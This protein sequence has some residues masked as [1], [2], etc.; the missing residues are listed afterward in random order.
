MPHANANFDPAQR[1]TKNPFRAMAAGEIPPAP[2]SELLGLKI[3]ELNEAAGTCTIEFQ[4]KP[5]FV[6][7]IG[8]IQGGFL[9]A[10]LDDTFSIALLA[11]LGPEFIAPTVEMN[12]SFIRA[13]KPGKLIGKGRVVHKGGTIGFAESELFDAEGKLIARASATAAVRKLT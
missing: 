10:M 8:T 9:A 5:E 3:L 4:G 13:A 6:N 1:P 11:A 12:V 2:A 7:P